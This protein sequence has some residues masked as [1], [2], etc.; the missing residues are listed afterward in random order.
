MSQIQINA[1]NFF[2]FKIFQM[3][4]YTNE[5]EVKFQV[6]SSIFQIIIAI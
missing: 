1:A 3:A 2:K 4:R 5:L 6:S